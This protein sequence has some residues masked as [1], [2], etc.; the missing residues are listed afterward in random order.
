MMG[1]KRIIDL[2]HRLIPGKEAFLLDLVSHNAD[3]VV[4][5]I[6]RR[7][8]LWYIL[9]DIHMSS[10]VGTHIE[11][12]YHHWKTGADASTFPIERLIGPACVLDF[13]HKRPYEIIERVELEKIPVQ[14]EQGDIVFIQTGCD[15]FI[16][17][18]KMYDRPVMST[19]AIQYLIDRGIHCI[20]TDA[21]GLELKGTDDQ[22]NHQ[23]LFK[24]NI[25]MVECATNLDALSK[26]RFFVTILPLAIQGLD[27]C[28]VRII[29][30]EE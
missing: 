1:Y 25:P 20:G 28:P 10:H 24:H 16:N 4:G 22:P 2:S 17:S 9:Q 15:K 3:E 23:L 6:K 8:D 27:A 5:H 29:A 19:E 11:L 21:T 7:K 18:D 14:V 26:E 30:F 12:P 13:S